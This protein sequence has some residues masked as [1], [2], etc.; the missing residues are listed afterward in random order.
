MPVGLFPPLSSVKDVKKFDDSLEKLNDFLESVEGNLAAYN[1]LLSQ[2]DFV[3][4]NM[5]D[6]WEYVSAAKHAENPQESRAN[7]DYGKRYLIL[8]AERFSGPA[9][10]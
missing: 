3:A 8:L 6:G 9:R 5:D 1:I 2:G 10:E 7:H 4:R